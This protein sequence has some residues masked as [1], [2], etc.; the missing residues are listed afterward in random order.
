MARKT[1]SG[2]VKKSNA[3]IRAHWAIESVWEPRIVALLA[4]KVHVEDEDFKLYEIP[5]PDILGTRHS[6]RDYQEIASVVDNIMGRVIT[7]PESTTRVHKYN[8]FSRCTI[9]TAKG[10]LELRFDADLKPHYLQLKERFTQYS[11]AEFMSLPSI[12]SQ[13][14]YEILKSWCDKPEVNIATDEL[15]NMLDASTS[16][17]ANFKDFRRRVLE[18]AHKDIVER[19]GSSLW[20]DWEP[21]K[22][23]RGGKVIAVRFVFSETKARELAKNQPPPD[24]LFV[25]QQLQR[26][27]NTCYERLAKRGQS[28]TPRLKTK[29]CQFCTTRGRMF[30][31]QKQKFLIEQEQEQA[32]AQ[33]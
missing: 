24:E 21:I 12:Y 13:R 9:D 26:Q 2:I 11:L 15:Y 14:L 28:C 18:Q 16:L 23:G 17:R 5:L 30:H 8:V 20:F 10:V 3:L 31:K 6:G 29:K 27:S 33:D 25:H 1:R 19:D 32:Q 4:S 22:H 7:I